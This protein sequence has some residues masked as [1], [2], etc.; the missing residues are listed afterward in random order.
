ME[1]WLKEIEHAST[2]AQVVAVTRDY[3]ALLHPRELEPLPKELRE[4]RI[5]GEADI[6]RVRKKLSEGFAGV[7]DPQAETAGLRDLVDYLARADERLG[8][9]RSPR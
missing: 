3:C 2:G 1:S 8:Q 5:E 7:R 6:S 4:I 9:L